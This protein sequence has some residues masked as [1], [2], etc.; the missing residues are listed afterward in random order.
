[1]WWFNKYSRF[2]LALLAVPVLSFGQNCNLIFKGQVIDESTGVALPFTSIYN[3]AT[4]NGVMADSLGNF[5]MKNLCAGSYQFQF[6]HIG[7]DTKQFRVDLQ[8][9]SIYTIFMNH[10]N[11]WLNE[12]VV[13]GKNEGNS[14]QV[15]NTL[16]TEQVV[17][18][19]NKDLASLIGKIQGVSTLKTGSGIS[20]PVI[21]GLYGNRVTILNNGIAQA[22]QQWGNDHAPE[23]DPFVANHISVIKGASALLYSGSS[24]GGVV[25]VEPGNIPHNEQLNGDVNYI[26]QTNGLGHTLNTHIGRSDDW[27]AW[28][29]TGTVKV[30]GDMQTPDYYLTNTGKR[31]GNLA[32]QLEKTIASRW[33]TNLYYSLYNTNIGI[34]RGAHIGN[35]TD[36]EDAFTRPI[37]FFTEDHFSYNI[38]SP[39]QEVQHHLLKLETNYLIS[40]VQSLKIKY[41]GQLDNR[42]EFDVRRGGRSDIPALSLWQNNQYLDGIYN[43]SLPKGYS[44]KTGIQL[45]YV[46]N[47]NNPETGILPLIPDYRSY[48]GAAILVLKRE[49]DKL[50]YELG[51]RYDV[52][53]LDVWAISRTLPREIETHNHVFND[54]NLSAG[55]TYQFTGFLKTNLDVGYVLRS[56][57]INELYSY[58]LHQGVSGIEIGNPEMKSEKSLKMVLSTDW[59]L[60]SKLF[61]QALGYY[62]NIHNFIYLQP[63]DEFELTIRGA[64][65]VFMYEQ[66]NAEIIGSDLMLSYEPFSNLKFVTKYSVLKGT[67]VTENIPLV[68]MPPNNWSATGTY[69]FKN[70][71]KFHNNSISIN[72]EYVFKQ[73]NYVDGQDFVPPPD[74]YFLLGFNAATVIPLEHHKNIKISVQGENVLN[75]KYRDYMNRQRYFADDVGI[76]L[77]LRVSYNF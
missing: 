40:D 58:G 9:D 52:K 37:P 35:L 19:G 11:E 13:H 6:S 21:Q 62:Q 27:A 44:L 24:L 33:H 76:N 31:E 45:N 5:E 75:K 73:K 66:T 42:K 56:P 43:L 23:I 12:V 25:L 2:I 53:Q 28:R 16:N 72:G 30:V 36:L 59:N 65:P 29:V 57:E 34:L 61:I 46:D 64:F 15:S 77:M 67:N 32:V 22:G 17:S 51:A 74:G 69:Y 50:F 63:Q 18:E 49:K 4:Q 54:Y 3:P 71:G 7:C 68:Y 55:A 70:P 26:F 48:N 60:G 20:K 8:R 47:V 10:H 38:N 1:M 41:G 39:R 14:T